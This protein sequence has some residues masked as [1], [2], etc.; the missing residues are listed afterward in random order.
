MSQSAEVRFHPVP[1]FMGLPP[2]R[3]PESGAAR[4]CVVGIPFDCGTHPFRVGSRQGPD[5]IR[6]QSRLL[7]P[8]DIFRRHGIDNPSE[9]LRAVDVGNVACHP[10]DPDASF[11]LIEAGIGAIRTRAPFPFRWA[12]M[13]R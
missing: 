13:A 3:S 4:A 12:A 2:A 11:P 8:V 9:F 10:G 1:G 7:R 5:A 6:E